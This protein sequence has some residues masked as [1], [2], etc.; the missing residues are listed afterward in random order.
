MVRLSRVGFIGVQTKAITPQMKSILVLELQDGYYVQE[1]I[2]P[3]Y[4]TSEHIPTKKD[5]SIQSITF[6]LQ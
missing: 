4:L 6:F 2:A 1:K 3:L 5:V